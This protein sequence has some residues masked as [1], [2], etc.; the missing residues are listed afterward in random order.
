MPALPFTGNSFKKRC[1]PMDFPPA[2]HWVPETP[3]NWVPF[4]SLHCPAEPPLFQQQHRSSRDAEQPHPCPGLLS[5]GVKHITDWS[6]ARRGAPAAGPALCALAQPGS[7]GCAGALGLLS[8]GNQS[9]FGLTGR[10]TCFVSL[11]SRN[12]SLQ[13]EGPE[14]P[15]ISPLNSCMEC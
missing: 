9:S 12:S 2:K 14:G 1:L 15:S 13:Q 3:R 11:P 6:E 7:R 5:P 10:G 4:P 8:T